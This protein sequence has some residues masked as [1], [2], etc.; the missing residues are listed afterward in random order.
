MNLD[1]S[2]WQ[3][4]Q[5]YLFIDR[6]LSEKSSS[7]NAITSRFRKLST[8]FS[9]KE[10]NRNNF[11]TFVADMRKQQYSASYINNMIKLAKHL[12]RFLHL[13]QLQDYTYF[14]EKKAYTLDVLSPKE[15]ELLASVR[16]SYKKQAEYLNQR[17]HA[18]IILIGTTGCRIGE[19]LNLR[20]SDIHSSPPYVILRDTK[21]GDDRVV[22]ISQQLYDILLALPIKTEFVF[23]SGR[24][25]ML[26]TQQVN[27]DLKQRAE[28]VGIKKNVY[29][30]L[31]RHSFVT[32]MLENGVDAL[33]VGVIVGHRDPKTTL[34]Y[35]NSLL[36]HYVDV[37]HVHPL[38]R[39]GQTWQQLTQRIK[40]ILMKSVDTKT[41][42]LNIEERDGKMIIHIEAPYGSTQS[43]DSTGSSHSSPRLNNPEHTSSQEGEDLTGN[44]K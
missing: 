15:I 34:R 26:E 20:F 7:R 4:F 5:T 22:P 11:N 1:Q 12:D 19:A 44:E 3:T 14:R 9:D 10:F 24:S 30:H 39:G 27:L 36:S 40:S 35:K 2:L 32:T 8:Y 29:A 28:A 38:V 42:S 17:Q 33:D 41:N 16:L 21:N 37:M 31:F 25:G 13:N 43:M 18:L 23:S 6:K